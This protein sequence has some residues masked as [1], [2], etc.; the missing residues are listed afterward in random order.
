MDIEDFRRDLIEAVRSRAAS[1]EDFSSAVF[2]DEAARRLAEAEELH[3]FQP[4]FFKGSGTRQRALRVD[5]FSDDDADD[6]FRLVI[7]DYRG[8]EHP[9]TLTFTD[10]T[11]LFGQLVAFLDDVMSKRFF[12]VSREESSPGYGLARVLLQRQDAI[13]RFRL[14]LV[15]DAVLSSRVVDLP[16]DSLHGCPVEYHVWD[17]ARFHR[18]HQSTIGTEELEVD[19]TEYVPGGL[20]C[21]EA[22]EVSSEYSAFLSIIPGEVLADIYDRYGSRLLE[23]NVRSFLST[24]G[25]VNKGI[26]ATIRSQPARFF[27]YNNGIAAAATWVEVARTPG[28]LRLR[29][30]RYLQIVNGGQTTAS[31]ATAKRKDKSD[32]SSIAVQMKL[33]VIPGEDSQRLDEMISNIARFANNQNKV[34][35]ADFFS[36][37]P[38]HRRLETISRRIWA[39]A[40]RGAQHG[41]HWFYERAR[42][43]YLNEQ[44]KMTPAMRRQFEMQNPRHQVITKTDLAKYE[45]AW[46]RKPHTVSLGAQKNFSAFAESVQGQWDREDAEFNEE[47]FREVVARAILFRRTERLVSQASWYQGGYRANIVAYAVALL[48]ALIDRR[49]RGM[50][51]NYRQIWDAQE[52][53]DALSRQLAL[54]AEAVYSVIISPEAGIQNVT[55]WCKKNLCWQRVEAL[56]I[57]LLDEFVEELESKTRAAEIHRGARQ[58]QKLVEGIDTQT[59]VF[60][61]GATYWAKLREWART[62]GAVSPLEDQILAV[63]CR[64]PT[65]IPTEKQCGELLRIK[66]RLEAEGA[67]HL[68]VP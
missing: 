27:A 14:Y 52:I 41:T 2:V 28:G 5:G 35:D 43:Q 4:C 25:K 48:S 64:I 68:A 26:Q 30:A 62:H 10:A 32:L 42:G 18:V 51:L 3:D 12:D 6:S 59:T 50:V 60:H 40:V 8:T 67:E 11:R 63:A 34:N 24:R 23:G 39:P 38:Y 21:I 19:F 55:E 61:L 45:N 13:T 58:E 65:R 44:V 17:V 22:G 46:G 47:Y 56:D 16:E 7:A 53:S 36:N 66:Q 9:E 54:L 33:S 15:T 57:D 20:P 37:H 31:L 1:E 29:R 49:A